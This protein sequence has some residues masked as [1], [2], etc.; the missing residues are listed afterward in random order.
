MTPEQREEFRR[1]MAEAALLPPEHP[2]RLA[3]V[4]RVAAADGEIEDEWMRLVQDDERLRV[5]LARVR[6]PPDLHRRLLTIPA[7]QPHARPKRVPDASRWAVGLTLTAL[8]AVAVVA[9]LLR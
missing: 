8:A 7:Q 1:R 3:V 5:E 2:V 4:A 9:W 6:P